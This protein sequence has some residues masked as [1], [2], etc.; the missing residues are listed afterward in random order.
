M[1]KSE[2]MSDAGALRLLRKMSSNCREGRSID[3]HNLGKK[4]PNKDKRGS[5]MKKSEATKNTR[6]AIR[7]M[8]G[9]IEN[10]RRARIIWLK[11]G[12]S[13][14]TH[15]ATLA[16]EEEFTCALKKLKEKKK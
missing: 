9:V 7:A 13:K 8:E 12:G 6:E 5:W 3:W 14:Q 15:D 16:V 1:K 4:A 11:N 2:T 10:H